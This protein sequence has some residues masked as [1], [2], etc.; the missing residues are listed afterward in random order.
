MFL[1]GFALALALL[2][3]VAWLVWQNTNHMQET[4][5]MVAH[6]HE[7]QANLNRLL[8]LLDDI[9]TGQR[10]FVI[11][12]DPKFLEPFESGLKAVADQ[13]QHLGQL[14]L[15]A[16]L[17]TNLSTL[18]TLI[19]ER[20]AVARRVVD[21]RRDSGFEAAQKEEASGIGK[22]IH[23]QIRARLAEMDAR[24]QTLLDDRSATARREADT[25]LLLTI[26][27]ESLGVAVLIAVFAL[28][29]RENRLRQQA[30]LALRRSEQ[31]L[32]VTLHSIGDAVLATDPE[33]RVTR[34][35]FVA[36]KLTGWT[37]A[38]ALGRPVAE[39]FNIINEKTREP[40]VIPVDNVLVTGE[41]HGLAN[42]TVIIARDGTE[43][44][45]ADSAAPIR[46]K[47][48]KVFGVVL[49]FRDLT[50]EKKAENVIRQSEE[51]F[52]AT[53][54]QMAVGIAHVGLDG[55]WLRVNERLCE[56]LGYSSEELLGLTFQDITH[57]DDLE[58]D[59]LHVRRLLAGEL[60]RYG[61]EKRY[62]R[63]DRS[64]VW[65]WLTVALVRKA[66]GEP[67]Y[68]ISVIEDIT[69]RKR[70]EQH[71]ADFKAAL[72]EHAIVA[73]TDVQ[74]KITYANDKFC[75]I[76]KYAREELLGQDHRLVNSGHHPKAFMREMWETVTSGR[77]W[78][79]EVK[80]RAKDG[81]CHWLDTTIV[82]FFGA[83]GKPA[84]FITIRTD[85]TG[86]KQAEEEIRRFNQ[87]LEELVAR[88]TAE[89]RES[90]LRFRLMVE[91]VEDY[92]IIMLDAGGHV[93]SWNAGAERIKG[94]R[95]EEIV[96]QHF[97]R[98]YPPEDVES[99][100]PERALA[101]ATAEGRFE[102]EDLR[103]RQD[104]SRLIANVVITALRDAIGQLRGFA[105]I[106]RDI[107][108]RKQAENQLLLFR[109]LLDQ[110]T[111]AILV[112]NPATARIVDVNESA[113][114]N[115]GYTRAELL[116]LRVMDIEANFT[117][118]AAF[119]RNTEQ[120]KAAGAF[121]FEG[122]QRRKDGSTFPVEVSVRY[123][124]RPEGDYSLA[125][126][127]DITERKLV[128]RQLHRTQRL[129]S[130]G[131]LTGGI[132][133]DLNNALAPIM[134]SMEMLRVQ[135]P[136]ET[137]MLDII[138]TSAQRG[139]DMVRQ[140][141]TFAKGAE[142][143][144]VPLQL[145]RLVKEMKKIMEGSFPKNIE[146][147]IQCDPKLPLVLG[148]TTQLHQVF[149]NLCVNARD[150]MPNG[151]TLTLEAASQK[152]DA[153]YASLVPDAKPGDY[154]TLR[155]H[156]TGTGIPPEIIDRI[157][158][159]FFTT[160]GPDQGTGLGL[161]TVIGIVKGHGGFLQVSSQPGHGS[162]FIVFL[163]VHSAGSDTEHII[164]AAAGFCGQGETILIV[165]DETSVRKVMCAVLRRLNFSPL[166]ATDGAD[167]IIRAAENR[168]ELRAVITDLQMPHMDGLAFVRALRR[169][170]PDIPVAVASGRMDDA[171]A[172]EFKTLGVTCRLNKPFAEDQ[173]AET[174]K[175]LLAPK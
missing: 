39:V 21:L 5:E 54:E 126:A 143:A 48:G 74:G 61:M 49:V 33:G 111:D 80:N 150:A 108:V 127:R 120:L 63:K 137:Q 133:H 123:V 164:K 114:R 169:M 92:A 96:G 146:L 36:E 38:E 175:N 79:G 18:G 170:L 132:A 144:H 43:R 70:A 16:A 56:L 3:C 88:R 109:A 91:N 113:C 141:L 162:T 72:D 136:L 115:L 75:T 12:G 168:S 118:L 17:K 53:F 102:E 44:P 172:A 73:I 166:A 94:Y 64:L 57:A 14:I 158:D 37:Q 68:F 20:I 10:G 100:R 60:S 147:N 19:A 124:S 122:R 46:N 107:T 77:I 51:R 23:D 89:L 153:T 106:V 55:R 119:H 31:K 59:L 125:I 148:D 87:G 139:A 117:D 90:D 138:Q 135:Y 76:S 41:I 85:I 121:H 50:E 58:L 28:V 11:T 167:G 42:H 174:L 34:L 83:D 15:D 13:Q 2:V 66:S 165:E 98:F 171:V 24:E 30:N 103:V 156:D 160:K 65:V 130:I 25:T 7:V 142:G 84:Q 112:A 8:T 9:E 32:A 152:L 40:A 95:A 140:L 1:A 159:P 116:A 145:G 82:P 155:V 129:E 81:S 6:T 99:G 97:S 151:G 4:A 52:R 67:D 161:S 62:W 47:D 26:I 22:A 86:Q 110:S 105:K 27:G 29:L 149:L 131:T 93:A 157:F 128:E 173:L 134:I 163:P 104:G 69:K 35:N 71:L 78:H 101:V 154:V 45:I